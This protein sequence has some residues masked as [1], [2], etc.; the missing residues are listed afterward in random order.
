VVNFTL[1]VAGFAPRQLR[2]YAFSCCPMKTFL[3][4]LFLFTLSSA[5]VYAQKT[6]SARTI[7]LQLLNKR[8]P[9][10]KWNS[11]SLIKGDFDYDGIADYALSGRRGD[12]FVVGIIKGS[13]NRKSKHWT[14]EFS[15][16][17]GSQGSLCSVA[18]ARISSE[19]FAP[20]DEITEVRRL[21]KKSRG[22]NLSDESCDSFH[23]YYSRK[24]K[25]FVL[26][27]R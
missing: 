9:N 7:A 27:R 2:R 24:E 23:I 19:R 14:L 13:L 25:Q 12:R 4:I 10:V 6:S 15:Q 1:R 18:D 22:I 26:W 20:D 16:D 11:R 3:T 17:A 5:F 21:P 8:E